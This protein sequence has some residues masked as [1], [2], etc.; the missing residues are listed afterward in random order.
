MMYATKCKWIFYRHE[1]LNK[2]KLYQ[3]CVICL[4][5]YIK[6]DTGISVIYHWVKEQ[7]KFGK[8]NQCLIAFFVVLRF[9][10]WSLRTHHQKASK[11]SYT[12]LNRDRVLGES[13]LGSKIGIKIMSFDLTRWCARVDFNAVI[14]SVAEGWFTVCPVVVRCVTKVLSAAPIQ[15]F[16][17]FVTLAKKCSCN[18]GHASRSRIWKVYRPTSKSMRFH[19]RFKSDS[20]WSRWLPTFI[21]RF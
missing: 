3:E 14:F 4:K 10:I 20:L 1:I 5:T 12:L 7:K 18:G 16:V 8:E 19:L 13:T 21:S 6:F 15:S 11:K 2:Q 17:V 9:C